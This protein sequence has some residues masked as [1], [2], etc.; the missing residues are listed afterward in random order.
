FQFERTSPD[1]I[2]GTRGSFIAGGANNK[3]QDIPKR[4][5]NARYAHVEG[6]GNRAHE[7]YAH[8]EGTSCIADGKISHAEGNT[9]ICS[10]NDSHAEGNMTVTGRKYFGGVTY[11]SEDAGDSLGVLQYVLIPDKEGDVTSYFPNQLTDNITVRYGVGA[12]KDAKGNIYASI[13][14]PA[15]WTGDTVTTSNDLTWAL[16]SICIARGTGETDIE[17]VNIA[18]A[19]Y[20]TGVGSKIYYFGASPFPTI[21]GI[22]SSYAP[23]VEIGGIASVNGQHAEGLYT[24]TFGTAAHA[25]G[26][27][28][29]AWGKCTHAEGSGTAATGIGAHSEGIETLA[30]GDASHASGSKTKASGI[31]SHAKGEL[32]E[33]AGTYSTASGFKSKAMGSYS[34]AQGEECIASG[35]SSY[36][37]GRYSKASRDFQKSYAIGKN[38]NIGDNQTTQ[39]SYNSVVTGAGWFPL[40][41]LKNLEEGKAYN[42]E[43][44][45]LG[46]QSAGTAGVIGQTF[47]YKFQ[48]LI[49]YNGGVVALVG[50]PTRVLV[51][52][53]ATL[54]GD[55]LTTGIR[56]SF[57]TA[58]SGSTIN[59]AHIRYDGLADTTFTI[60][61]YSTIQEMGL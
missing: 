1:Q 60:Q 36:A 41:A 44:M 17:F 10:A 12:K 35:A 9:T 49:I 15:V 28:T 46:R 30:S 40:W 55:G 29:R 34:E 53:S 56:C 8:A 27:S 13:H 33:A 22:Y 24:S 47:A 19:V 23:I 4:G 51:G 14:T 42:I 32:T 6:F 7:W 31:C 18:K 61:T 43:T 26:E 25:E 45:V 58:Y 57:G 54:D 59:H 20:T 11:G 21:K 48:G 3:I 38:S 2:A 50:T 39:I 5:T 52:R 16:H 37:E